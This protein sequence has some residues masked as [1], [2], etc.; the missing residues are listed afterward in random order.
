MATL[1][2]I[3]KK[4]GDLTSVYA[5]INQ[6]PTAKNRGNLRRQLKKANTPDKIIT[7]NPEDMKSAAVK[8]S[9]GLEFTIDYAPPGAEYGKWWNEPTVAKNIKNAKTKNVPGSINFAEQAINDKE[10][11]D[12]IISYLDTLA[13]KIAD[14]FQNTLDKSIDKE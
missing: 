1:K 6:N 8:N 11:D 10:V 3:A 9:F 7:Q 2:D 14:G 12:L 4:I 5:P 13:D